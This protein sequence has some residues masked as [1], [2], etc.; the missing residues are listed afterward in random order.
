VT[1]VDPRPRPRLVLYVRS[2]T[3]TVTAR[4]WSLT[5]SRPTIDALYTLLQE[6]DAV[7]LVAVVDTDRFVLTPAHIM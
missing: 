3:C 7:A 2:A 4:F 6:K 1:Y 5:Y